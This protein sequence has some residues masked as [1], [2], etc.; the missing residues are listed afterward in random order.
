M[1]SCIHNIPTCILRITLNFSNLQNAALDHYSLEF[2]SY[3]EYN[4]AVGTHAPRYPI[5]GLDYPFVA[6]HLCVLTPP[7]LLYP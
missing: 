5:L 3:Q 4:V 7:P 2:P 1:Q 6:V